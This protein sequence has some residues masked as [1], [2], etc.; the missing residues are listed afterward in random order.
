M[1]SQALSV[2]ETQIAKAL[3]YLQREMQSVRAG[4]ANPMLRS[5]S[6]QLLWHGYPLNQMA[7]I[8]A[9]E[10]RLLTVQPYDK[11]MI[12]PIEKAIQMSELGINPSNDGKMIRL[13]IPMLT[14]ENRRE[15]TKLIKKMGEEAKIAVR[16]DRRTANDAIKK[17]L[18]DSTLREDE[19]KRLEE[20]VQEK[21]DEAIK[22]IDALV[23]EKINEIMEV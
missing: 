21:V 13:V 14:E 12:G 7:N 8:A 16:N 5:H 10:P 1:S 23:D 20:D 2:L 17:D 11:S 3:S 6:R 18:K 19:A 9:P 22:K 4:R 15:L